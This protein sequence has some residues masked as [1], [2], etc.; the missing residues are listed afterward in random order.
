MREVSQTDDD[1]IF[2][3]RLGHSN[4]LID[5]IDSQDIA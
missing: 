3:S 5:H 1:S 2:A 4:I